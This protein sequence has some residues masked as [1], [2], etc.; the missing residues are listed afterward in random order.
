MSEKEF[1]NI[2]REAAIACKTE[3][4]LS[5]VERAREGISKKT[6][7]NISETCGLSLKELSTLLPVSLRTIQR[8][9]EDERLEPNISEKALI[10]AE[11]LGKGIDVFGSVEK[12]QHWI[13]TPSIA[14]GNRTP[15]SLL[16]TSFGARMVTDLL[17]RIEHG[18]YS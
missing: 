2:I 3:N 8:Y 4:D 1:E 14:L 9:K 16:D 17:G 13:R 12:L 10:I 15:I 6:L 18:V 5:L 7:S 11:V